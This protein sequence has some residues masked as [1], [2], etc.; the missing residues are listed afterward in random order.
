MAILLEVKAEQSKINTRLDGQDK[1]LAT[2]VEQ[3]KEMYTV[4]TTSKTL[5]DAMKTIGKW[6]IGMSAFAAASMYLKHLFG[7]LTP[8]K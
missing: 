8:S 6:V 4:L 2:V 5:W 1:V 3:N 7:E